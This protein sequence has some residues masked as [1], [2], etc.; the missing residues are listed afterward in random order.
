MSDR[1]TS[2]GIGGNDWMNDALCWFV[3]PDEFHPVG[4]G[5]SAR[6]AKTACALCPV[7][8][9]CLAYAMR[10]EPVSHR[11]GIYGGLSPKERHQLARTPW[12]PG[13]EPPPIRLGMTKRDAA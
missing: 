4:T 5:A 7:R 9:A 10:T 2:T 6:E 12:R 3:T 8:A 13:D 11:E 1:G